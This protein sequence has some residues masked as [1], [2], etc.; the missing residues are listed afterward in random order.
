MTN[1]KFYHALNFTLG[2]EDW[3]VEQQALRVNDGDR[4]LCVTA[5]GDR[6][7]HLLT[8]PCADIIAVDMNRVQNYLLEL[9][10][11]AIAHFDYEKYLAF[12]GCRPTACRIRLYKE[13]RP[14]LSP[15]TAAYWSQHK[16]LLQR[17][18]IFQGMTERLM[19]KIAILF[20]FIARRKIQTLFSFTEIE[21]QREYVTNNWDSP[22]LKRIFSVM[23]HPRIRRLMISDPG[24]N[25]Y[26]DSSI[27]PGNYIYERMI[28]YLHHHLAV[29]SPMMHL[30][31]K[32][33][34]KAEAHFPYLSFEGYQAIRRAPQRLRLVTANVIDYLHAQDKESIDCFSMSDI[35]SYMSQK[36]FQQLL[37][38]INRAAK[39]AARFCLREFMSKHQIPEPL[40]AKFVRHEALEQSLELAEKHF[41]YRFMVGHIAA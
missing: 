37:L 28:R 27:C 1:E 4:V 21:A 10:L 39:P 26:V 16:K 25:A 5:S 20:S 3:E 8:T 22:L 33:G 13:L 31:F 41:I 12:L 11:T 2:N 38:G 18:V 36:H 9:K 30:L 6:P 19:N 14:H 40:S 24:L 17:G 29:D 7:L 23:A 32:S 15:E 34:L 35:A